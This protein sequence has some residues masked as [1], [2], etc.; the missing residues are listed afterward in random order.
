MS[1]EEMLESFGLIDTWPNPSTI[2][3]VVFRARIPV[4]L[5]FPRLLEA[6]IVQAN[7]RYASANEVSLPL[8]ACADP[9]NDNAGPSATHPDQQRSIYQLHRATCH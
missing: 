3:A 4:R 7:S 5:N 6:Q 1:E 8:P 9:V 2:V